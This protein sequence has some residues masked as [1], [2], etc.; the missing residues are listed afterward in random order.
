M[1][2]SSRR[3]TRFSCSRRPSGLTCWLRSRG[4][5]VAAPGQEPLEGALELRHALAV[6]GE[7]L[8][9]AV[10]PLVHLARQALEPAVGVVDPGTQVA[11]TSLICPAMDTTIA[12]VSVMVSPFLLR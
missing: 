5:A 9:H 10:E 3:R 1:V 7:L 11:F 12:V 4:V 2:L 8:V 6:L